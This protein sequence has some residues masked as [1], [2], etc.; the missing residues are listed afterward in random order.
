MNQRRLGR[1]KPMIPNWKTKD[2]KTWRPRNGQECLMLLWRKTRTMLLFFEKGVF[3][4]KIKTCNKTDAW[5]RQHYGDSQVVNVDTHWQFV[6]RSFLFFF[7]RPLYFGKFS[8]S[9]LPGLSIVRYSMT[10]K[11]KVLALESEWI[12]KK[13]VKPAIPVSILLSLR[14]TQVGILNISFSREILTLSAVM[15]GC[16]IILT[17]LSVVEFYLSLFW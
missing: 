10:E 6:W 8:S 15:N 7:S 13:S 3:F 12:T 1:G 11:K 4:D 16:F 14:I 17:E 5:R 2:N 9:A